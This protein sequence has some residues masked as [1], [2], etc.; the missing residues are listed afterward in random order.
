MKSITM[1][2][3]IL[4]SLLV[5]LTAVSCTNPRQRFKPYSNEESPWNCAL[6]P[7]DSIESFSLSPDGA[8][9][10][11]LG[12][13][14]DKWHF[15]VSAGWK[16]KVSEQARIEADPSRDTGRTVTLSQDSTRAAI[17][18]SRASHWRDRGPRPADDSGG[19]WFVM[20][21]R[22]IFGGFDRDFK[23]TVH[24]LKDGSLFGF[25]YKKMGQYCVQVA[26]TTFGPYER[27]DV[28]F[29]RDGEIYLGYLKQ[30]RAYIEMIKRQ[31]DPVRVNPSK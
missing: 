10:S 11:F 27:A 19:Q 14:D 28:A 9:I 1:Y 16:W 8:R 30:G 20:I 29:T 17:V 26:D 7:Y 4:A 23:P 18:Y 2:A 22:H 3:R 31:D 24:F 12:K 5:A 21:D 25:P 15:V 6:A 13:K